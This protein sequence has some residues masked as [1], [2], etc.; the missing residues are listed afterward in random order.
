MR[1]YAVLIALLVTYE[2]YEVLSFKRFKRFKPS[3]S[4]EVE[5]WRDESFRHPSF[6]EVSLPAS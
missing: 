5:G 1:S 6:Q 4:Y 2:F 3:F